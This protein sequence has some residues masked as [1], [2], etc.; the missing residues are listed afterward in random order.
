MAS[1]RSSLKM[2]QPLSINLYVFIILFLCRLG[3][4]IIICLTC[5][6]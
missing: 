3:G 4:S 6:F 1:N 5:Q 2:S